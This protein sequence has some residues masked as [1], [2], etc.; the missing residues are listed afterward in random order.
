[1]FD[2]KNVPSNQI[3]VNLFFFELVTTAS[4]S[5]NMQFNLFVT[6]IWA[7]VIY[8][9]AETKSAFATIL[10]KGRIPFMSSPSSAQ[11]RIAKQK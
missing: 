9:V 11:R 3:K 2:I 5:Q 1:M 7:N 8:T 4:R 10:F 6:W